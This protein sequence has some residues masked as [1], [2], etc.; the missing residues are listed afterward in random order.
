MKSFLLSAGFLA[1]FYHIP[2]LPDLAPLHIKGVTTINLHQAKRLHDIGVPFID[3][4]PR[5]QWQ[6]GHI[7]QSYNLELQESFKQLI[8]SN[9]TKKNTPLVIYGSS[10]YRMHG[11]IASYLATLWGYQRIFFLREGYYAWL[12]KDFPVS[13]QSD[14]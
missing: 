2:A 5:Q 14:Q 4:R 11:A 10:L 12:A 9:E 1:L 7:S 13:L 6:W 3:I 8:N